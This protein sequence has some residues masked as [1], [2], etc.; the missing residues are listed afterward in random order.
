MDNKSTKRKLTNEDENKVTKVI[1]VDKCAMKRSG[2]IIGDII[3]KKARTKP[4]KEEIAWLYH[5]N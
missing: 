1:K 4:T 3:R 2:V 5:Y